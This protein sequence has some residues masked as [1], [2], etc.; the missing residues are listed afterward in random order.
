MCLE[1]LLACPAVCICMCNTSACVVVWIVCFRTCGGPN[2]QTSVSERTKN[3]PLKVAWHVFPTIL[4]SLR[5]LLFH[6]SKGIP[7]TK[8][9]AQVASEKRLRSHWSLILPLTISL[10][11]PARSQPPT[12][13]WNGTHTLG[14]CQRR[15][16]NEASKDFWGQGKS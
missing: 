4:K 11:L 2:T 16:S 15:G 13:E 6:I 5:F 12:E 1:Y 8:I 14:L 10:S 7:N 3:P 9:R